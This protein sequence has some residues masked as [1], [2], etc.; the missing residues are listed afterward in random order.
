MGNDFIFKSIIL[1]K[2][3]AFETDLIAKLFMIIIQHNNNN[4]AF[5][6][7]NIDLQAIYELSLFIPQ[8][9]SCI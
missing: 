3:I 4:S 8:N 6:F 2:G 9:V 5:F 1:I 7:I